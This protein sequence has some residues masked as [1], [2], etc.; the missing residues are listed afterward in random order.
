VTAPLYLDMKLPGGGVMQAFENY[1]F[2]FA[3]S[4]LKLSWLRYGNDGLTGQPAVMH[5]VGW[6]VEKFADLPAGIRGYVEKEAP[7]W[8]APPVDMAEIKQL[9]QGQ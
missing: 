3:P 4:G 8:K 1:D 9:Q 2:F 7:L 6:R 5:M